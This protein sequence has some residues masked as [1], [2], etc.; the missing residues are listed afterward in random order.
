MRGKSLLARKAGKE[1]TTMASEA[2]LESPRGAELDRA[3]T[4]V[5]RPAPY[6]ELT[7]RDQAMVCLLRGASQ[8]DAAREA[9]V[10]DRTV[11]SWQR[12]PEFARELAERRRDALEQT[13]GRLQ[14]AA[15]KAVELLEQIVGDR[16]QKM[17]HRINAAKTILF[18]SSKLVAQLA[19][20]SSP[21]PAQSAQAAQPAAAGRSIAETETA[22]VAPH[23]RTL[24]DERQDAPEAGQPA[25]DTIPL[26]SRRTAPPAT[27][28][29]DSEPPNALP[30]NYSDF[31]SETADGERPRSLV[32]AGR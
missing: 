8:V 16:N 7:P 10:T 12:E 29:P 32:G 23:R 9:G 11:R 17:T 14:S 26:P 21:A 19:Q 30:R 22:A 18:W 27:R 20:P 24:P 28:F 4:A 1:E 31:S 13:C 2:L 6:A 15:E 3:G 25:S 5:R